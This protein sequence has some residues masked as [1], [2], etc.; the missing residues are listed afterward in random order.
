MCECV[1]LQ[2]TNKSYEVTNDNDVP[3]FGK[4]IIL[5]GTYNE[6]EYEKLFTPLKCLERSSSSCSHSNAQ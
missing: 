5:G 2:K 3:L 1:T 4:E 6:I